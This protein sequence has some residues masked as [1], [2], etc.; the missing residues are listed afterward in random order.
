MKILVLLIVLKMANMNS[1]DNDKLVEAIYKAEGGS[2][3]SY[4]YGIRSVHY[5][6]KQEA[7]QICLRTVVN[8]KKRFMQQ[9]KYNDYLEF[10]GSRYC[11]VSAH[12]LNKNWLKNVRYYLNEKN[13]K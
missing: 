10:L 1:Y 11:P 12:K 13:Q 3:A 9:Y 2:K 7:R 8:N 4:L 6:N 5:R